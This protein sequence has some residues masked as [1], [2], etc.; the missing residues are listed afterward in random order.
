MRQF[1]TDDF[2]FD[3]PGQGWRE[4]TLQHFSPEGDDESA[5]M[6]AR[7]ERAPD[8]A[9]ALTRTFAAF[10]KSAKLEVELVRSEEIQVGPL[11]G[12][13]IGIIARTTKGADYMR[14]VIVP[15]Y[16]LDLY[17]NWGGPAAQRAA[18]DGRAARA[19]ETVRFL[20]R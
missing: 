3:L 18:I 4:E 1:S 12:T 14:V 16:D 9:E 10:P 13:D 19:L 8:A 7:R 11:A 2:R 15:Y 6:I 17:L 5:F 20:R